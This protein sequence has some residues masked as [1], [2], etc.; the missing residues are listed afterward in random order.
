M[1]DLVVETKNLSVVYGAQRALTEV[2][3]EVE[4]GSTYALLGRNGA[5]KSSLIRCLL[6]HRR[7]SAG[8]LTVLGLDPWRERSRLMRRVGFVPETPD[9]PPEMSLRS[10]GSFCASLDPRFSTEQFQERLD[11]LKLPLRAGI[12]ELSRGQQ[13]QVQLALALASSPELLVLDDPTLGLDAVAR[14]EVFAELIDE[15]A[16]REVNLLV[17]THDLSGIEALAT[18]VGLLRSGELVLSQPI[19][20]LKRRF[21]RV[22]ASLGDQPD[23]ELGEIVCSRRTALG[24]EWIVSGDSDIGDSMS[25]EEIFLAM[26]EEVPADV[27]AQEG[28]PSLLSKKG[29]RPAVVETAVT[30]GYLP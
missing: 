12:A 11:R 18:H 27:S 26:A 22:V 24:Q 16:E 14:Q 23:P 4:R 28:R 8:E 25:L 5:G 3:L 9:L 7:A 6:G 20:T 21:R 1:S 15:L 10:A 13:T 29:E 19:D 30:K 2:S 17:T